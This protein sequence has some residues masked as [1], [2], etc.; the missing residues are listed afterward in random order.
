[1]RSNARGIHRNPKRRPLYRPWGEKPGANAARIR[2]RRA[3]ID[4]GAGRDRTLLGVAYLV[5]ETVAELGN[6]ARDLVEVDRLALPAA[7]VDVHGVAALRTRRSTSRVAFDCVF[8]DGGGT[9]AVR[10][11]G[12]AAVLDKARGWRASRTIQ[13]ARKNAPIRNQDGHLKTSTE[14]DPA[15]AA[16]SLSR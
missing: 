8:C 16:F 6:P 4:D 10:R 3:P 1:M 7:L 14:S 12:F 11:G 9:S 13:S 5:I 2:A 15:K